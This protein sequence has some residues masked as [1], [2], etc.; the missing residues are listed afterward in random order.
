VTAVV[1]NDEDIHLAIND[2]VNHVKRKPAKIQTA[3]IPRD[4][5]IVRRVSFQL[6]FSFAQLSAEAISGP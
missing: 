4:E 1:T 3:Q 5:V 6:A 2:F